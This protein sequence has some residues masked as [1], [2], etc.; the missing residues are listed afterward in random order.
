MEQTKYCLCCNENV[1]FN[2]IKRTEKIELT[3]AYC[4]FI[5]EIQQVGENKTS[6]K[7][8]VQRIPEQPITEDKAGEQENEELMAAPT[9]PE[10]Q[11]IPEQLI[12]EDKAGEQENEELLTTSI[13]SEE[14]P[15]IVKDEP[16][17]LQFAIEL[18]RKEEKVIPKEQF[19]EDDIKEQKIVT[20]KR[21]YKEYVN[22][23]EDLLRTKNQ[24]EAFEL[25]TEAMEYYPYNP[26]ILSYRGYIEALVNKEYADGIKICRESF[27]ILKSQMSLAEG[28]FLPILYLNLGRTYLIANNKK[29]AYY[30][31]QKGLDVDK[32]NEVIL[33]ELKKIGIRRNPFF[34]FLKRSNPLNKYIGI[35]TYKL[36]KKMMRP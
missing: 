21:P 26:I 9:E 35:L 5:L 28:F 11:R 8:K 23:V 3:C 24:E 19:T 14:Q 12:T 32:N 13:E 33:K 31:F 4:G 1:P 15:H 2:T 6:T 25:L 7:P 30:S 16:E 34:P 29:D 18:L 10:V 22:E 27:K 17:V 36:Q 20:Q